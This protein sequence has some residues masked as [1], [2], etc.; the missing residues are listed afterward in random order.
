ME[1]RIDGNLDDR[2]EDIKSL[3]KHLIPVWIAPVEQSV[4]LQ[5]R[6]VRFLGPSAAVVLFAEHLYARKIGRRLRVVL[7]K[8]PPEL[9]AYC[10]FSGLSHHLRNESPPVPDHP[11]SETEPLR[12]VFDANWGMTRGV[13]RLL[14]RHTSVTE[15]FEESLRSCIMEIAHNIVDHAE[16]E[17]GGVWTARYFSGSQQLRFAFA[18][19]GRGV[20]R[21]LREAGREFPDAATALDKISRGGVSAMSRPNNMGMGVSNLGS[22]VAHMGGSTVMVSGDGMI[23]DWSPQ[24]GPQRSITLDHAFP[25][26]AVFVTLP[27]DG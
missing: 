9:N 5:L 16:S 23:C 20:H 10:Y 15:D 21:S 7:P 4:K 2:W 24:S 13:L 17:I 12:Q 25:G 11:K 26:T 1:I 19:R 22:I 18:D 8:E 27:V 6:D 14:R 3:L